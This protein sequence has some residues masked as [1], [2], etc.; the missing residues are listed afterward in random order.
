MK[1]FMLQQINVAN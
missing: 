1:H